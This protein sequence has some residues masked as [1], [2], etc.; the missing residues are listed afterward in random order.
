MKVWI[1]Q[2]QNVQQALPIK[3]PNFDAIDIRANAQ[4]NLQ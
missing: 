2:N 3:L 4:Q 1:H